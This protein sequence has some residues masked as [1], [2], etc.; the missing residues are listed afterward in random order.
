MEINLRSI[1]KLA[2]IKC[3]LFVLLTGFSCGAFS[4]YNY[5]NKAT[6]LITQNSDA[7][8]AEKVA[9]RFKDLKALV[10]DT[11][12]LKD[13]KYEW[14][15]G[16][17]NEDILKAK[18][19]RLMQEGQHLALLGGNTHEY[20]SIIKVPKNYSKEKDNYVIHE[21]SQSW[22]KSAGQVA[23]K[24]DPNTGKLNTNP[25]FVFE[26]I[27]DGRVDIKL[28]SQRKFQREKHCNGR[29]DTYLYLLN[30]YGEVVEKND[31]YY[32][33]HFP[34]FPS[35]QFSNDFFYEKE[36]LSYEFSI[37]KPKKTSSKAWFKYNEVCPY[38]SAIS[39]YLQP[40]KYRLVAATHDKGVNADFALS[41]GA[42]T[43]IISNL[44]RDELSKI[45]SVPG[46]WSKSG[47]RDKDA[48]GNKRYEF[49][50]T[51]D[52]DVT[53]NLNADNNVDTFLYLLN[54]D[55]DVVASDDDSGEAY[56]AKISKS[57]P[58]GRYTIVAATFDKDM[59]GG[60]S[61][62]LDAPIVYELQEQSKEKEKESQ[63]SFSTCAPY[64]KQ[65]NNRHRVQ[66][67][68]SHAKEELC[69]QLIGVRENETI[70][71]NTENHDI[72][73]VDLVR[74]KDESVKDKALKAW[75][76]L[77]SPGKTTIT[78]TSYFM[79]NERSLSF[80]LEILKAFSR[81]TFSSTE[82]INVTPANEIHITLKPNYY[83]N[84]DKAER[85]YLGDT[86]INFLEN[87]EVDN[88]IH[89]LKQI[90]TN[91]ISF[92]SNNSDV[93]SH[94][95]SGVFRVKTAGTAEIEVKKNEDSFS[96]ASS[97]TLTVK[98][99]KANKPEE[100]FLKKWFLLDFTGPKIIKARDIIRDAYGSPDEFFSFKADREGVINDLGNGE[101]KLKGAGKVNVTV[102]RRE[103]EFSEGYT[104]NIE[105]NVE[106]A[107]L[108]GV[109]FDNGDDDPK[110]HQ[111]RHKFGDNNDKIKIKIKEPKKYKRLNL[112]YKSTNEDI[113]TVDNQGNVTIKSPG[114]VKINIHRQDPDGIFN[115]SLASTLKI[116]IEKPTL[117][118]A[119]QKLA[120]ESDYVI[121]PNPTIDGPPSSEGISYKVIEGSDVVEVING[122]QLK[123]LGVGKAI[124]EAELE[125]TKNYKGKSDPFYVE[126]IKGTQNS[127][128]VIGEDIQK[129]DTGK[130]YIEK[131]YRKSLEIPFKVDGGSG[132]GEWDIRNSGSKVVEVVKDDKIKGGYKLKV[133]GSGLAKITAIKRGGENYK[134]ATASIEVKIK[135]GTQDTLKIKVKNGI[136]KFYLDEIIEVSATGGSVEE[137]QH[138]KYSVSQSGRFFNLGSGKFQ[139]I[140]TLLEDEVGITATLEGN[141]NYEKAV[142]NTIKVKLSQPKGLNFTNTSLEIQ[143]GTDANVDL[144]KNLEGYKAIDRKEIEF[145]NGFGSSN[146]SVDANGQLKI[147]NTG[148][149]RITVEPIDKFKNHFS[150]KGSSINI[151]VVPKK[152]QDKPSDPKPEE[153]K[154][155]GRYI[156]VTASKPTEAAD[157]SVEF[158]LNYN[159]SDGEK[160]I[161]SFSL[162][163]FYDSKKLIWNGLAKDGVLGLTDDDAS[164]TESVIK[165]WGSDYG[166]FQYLT[167]RSDEDLSW[168]DNDQNTTR[169]IYLAWS[170]SQEDDKRT[171][172]DPTNEKGFIGDSSL[173][174]E[175]IKKLSFSRKPSFVDGSTTINFFSSKTSEGNMGHDY[176]FDA[177]PI[178]IYGKSKS[179][180][181]NP[182]SEEDKSKGKYIEVTATQAEE[183]DNDLVEVSLKYNVSDGATNHKYLNVHMHYD[184]EKLTWIGFEKNTALGMH[185]KFKSSDNNA[186][187]NKISKKF[188][189]NDYGELSLV[190]DYATSSFTSKGVNFDVNTDRLVYLRWKPQFAQENSSYD[191]W[192][193]K[194]GF[195]GNEKLPVKLIKVY[196]TRKTGFDSGAT[197]ITFTSP[198]PPKGDPSGPYGFDA[199]PI[200]IY[201]KPK[202]E[203]DKPKGKYIEITPNPTE[204]VRTPDSDNEVTFSVDYDVSDDEKEGIRSLLLYMHYDD[205]KLEWKGVQHKGLLGFSSDPESTNDNA[206]LIKSWDGS[207]ASDQGNLQEI[208]E[209]SEKGS[210]ENDNNENTSRLVRFLWTK[211]WTNDA[212]RD[213]SHYGFVGPKEFP[214]KLFKTTFA[215]KPDALAAN[216]ST[217]I[218]FSWSDTTDGGYKLKS[219][220]VTIYGKPKELAG[221]LDLTIEKPT[222]LSIDGSGIKL[223]ELDYDSCEI[224]YSESSFS[225]E[226]GSSFNSNAWNTQLSINTSESC[227]Q[228]NTN[229]ITL[230]GLQSDV[231]YYVMM[232]FKD[233]NGSIIAHSKEHQIKLPKLV[234]TAEPHDDSNYTNIKWQNIAD[235][236]GKKFTLYYDV[237]ND[238]NNNAAKSVIGED[239]DIDDQEFTWDTLKIPEG[240]YY[241]YAII[242]GE[243]TPIYSQKPITIKHNHG[244]VMDC[245]AMYNY[246]GGAFNAPYQCNKE[247][248]AL[249]GSSGRVTTIGQWNDSPEI[250][251]TD[252]P[253]KVIYPS[254][255]HFMLE[256]KD[257]TYDLHGYIGPEQKQE[258]F[259]KNMSI[260]SRD[261]AF[262]GVDKDNDVALNHPLTS[263]TY[264]TDWSE[265]FTKYNN[266]L[267]SHTDNHREKLINDGSIANLIYPLPSSDN[268]SY[269]NAEDVP[270]FKQGARFTSVVTNGSAK[271]A[272][273]KDGRIKIWGDGA[274]GGRIP[275]RDKEV[276]DSVPDLNQTSFVKIYSGSMGFSAVKKDKS[277]IYWGSPKTIRDYPYEEKITTKIGNDISKIFSNSHFFYGIKNDGSVKV[278]GEISYNDDN[279]KNAIESATDVINIYIAD[280]AITLEDKHGDLYWTSTMPSHEKVKLQK[281][282]N[283][284]FTKISSN[285]SAF[286]GINL[287]GSI[288]SWGHEKCGG[289]TAPKDSGYIAIYSTDCSFVAV[290]A[291]GSYSTW[292]EMGEN[293]GSLE[294]DQPK[295]K[296]IEIKPE[297]GKDNIYFEGEDED[298]EF[299]MTLTVD[300]KRIPSLHLYMYYDYKKLRWNGLV[301]SSILG[302][303]DPKGVNAVSLGPTTVK[304]I[305][306]EDWQ[307]T[308]YGEFRKIHHYYG[309]LYNG[310]IKKH[311]EEGNFNDRDDDTDA[312]IVV[313]WSRPAIGKG[314]F[315]SGSSGFVER[316]PNNLQL[317]KTSFTPKPGF[318]AG[319]ST[320]IN[321]LIGQ[322]P[323]GVV[324][325]DYVL[326]AK[327]VTITN[328]GSPPPE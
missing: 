172:Q 184:S 187:D 171:F 307:N 49:Y 99:L 42:K 77:K 185:S 201:G 294:E 35:M 113:A 204:F 296:Y 243:S 305:K 132:S 200:T 94:Y 79:G 288:R 105:L 313:S 324:G 223:S 196:F 273:T 148:F 54:S 159:V 286:A 15:K 92:T 157:N 121:T 195:I 239:I 45:H 152:V 308:K 137:D 30:E 275:W 180:E 109:E 97:N 215:L 40:G 117:N 259:T 11:Y 84:I 93:L 13:N 14:S 194:K 169:L 245:S 142:S 225:H 50:L 170:Y 104:S 8:E 58:S 32:Y 62:R 217:K 63:L 255:S 72:A 287:K 17:G 192:S 1:Y 293:S 199:D 22:A 280:T 65:I 270:N 26:V 60:F 144:F 269:K 248:F 7:V 267:G 78:A 327:S 128:N 260:F 141:K 149:R 70:V 134:D 102:T 162:G 316:I 182:K 228:G 198:K 156:E 4:S 266:L 322:Q 21:K 151:Q 112:V 312:V 276:Y 59:D 274:V 6:K 163:V 277:V 278:W 136:T 227:G 298:I 176:E 206:N 295:G 203:E 250:K 226:D 133:I 83:R 222:Q 127:L 164:S 61:L 310:K 237:N 155:K 74:Q 120:Y 178:T 224:Y 220:S 235:L 96:K 161:R 216:E 210:D 304:T 320:R 207:L 244:L 20:L 108:P 211:N 234:L 181:D 76:R 95:Y 73:A 297:D 36:Q 289:N 209:K 214:V 46:S 212:E 183:S 126:I 264:V 139:V 47:G 208:M 285:L 167:N 116:N 67:T 213:N 138:Y 51:E 314:T 129:N 299:A 179:E 230:K 242:E 268:D 145:S 328:K 87:T 189:A 219:K 130:N 232:V 197:K 19:S 69:I 265:D 292:G 91:T 111:L 246:L 10:Q 202:S 281:I 188:K 257:G 119:N 193:N 131:A 311:F 279:I 303:S 231:N 318:N 173:P 168:T 236:E 33:Y 229:N 106:S 16:K 2:S 18:L 146:V 103:D 28:I 150:N 253:Y 282:D 53:I 283:P 38:E 143:L 263:K 166:E 177:D 68:G 71:F 254:E 23:S 124:V 107:P 57:L 218:N 153:D 309:E 31:D 9:V 100:E 55:G 52:E 249:R 272:L 321:F 302:L 89:K 191:G 290:K 261:D 114:E 12:F 85:P 135:K 251:V 81:I 238:N 317:F 326:S 301:R 256:K 175:L 140:N 154:S 44:H 122:S 66:M 5:E 165:R 82:K 41:I 118:V 80:K 101:I 262:I 125:W 27:K 115:N 90:D 56:Q 37:L 300:T 25:H 98:V 319:G 174:V 247:T 291:D 190:E 43:G 252:D 323:K 325:H 233:S 315:T 110:K 205:S 258:K 123:I 284:K 221:T 88:G 34:G 86:F 64:S 186:T 29:T 24:I 75:I 158:S 306:E 240:D 241:L 147:K 39:R 3:L 271:A 48:S 160:G